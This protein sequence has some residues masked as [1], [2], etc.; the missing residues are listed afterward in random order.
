MRARTFRHCHASS[1]TPRSASR[2]SEKGSACRSGG[3]L[4]N[5]AVNLDYRLDHGA[6]RVDVV[7]PG[8][9]S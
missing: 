9:P 8:P 1:V 5:A 4:I 6:G 2:T 3:A 7:S